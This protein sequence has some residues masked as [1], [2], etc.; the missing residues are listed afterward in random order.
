MNTVRRATA[1]D[2]DAV[3]DLQRTIFPGDPNG[4][5]RREFSGQSIARRTRI[6]LAEGDDRLLG[7]GVQR[8]RGIR[9]WSGMDFMGVAVR[10]RG[11][12][13]GDALVAALIEDCMRPFARLFVRPSN[14][15][16]RKLYARHGF[17]QT[18]RRKGN[19][20]DGEDALVL[21]RWTGL[22]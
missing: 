20:A 10:A 22:L 14:A 6:L 4:L 1:A 16:A 3:M 9:P 17:R 2:A 19:Y 7:F 15:A 12:G 8:D 21:M 13:V 18:G 5:E 11:E